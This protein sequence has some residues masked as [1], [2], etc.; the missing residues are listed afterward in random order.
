MVREAPIAFHLRCHIQPSIIQQPCPHIRRS[1]LLVGGWLFLLHISH[2][3]FR[4]STSNDLLTGLGIGGNREKWKLVYF[5]GL[6]PYPNFKCVR[7]CIGTL[8]DTLKW[9]PSPRIW[10]RCWWWWCLADAFALKLLLLKAT[11]P[12]LLPRLPRT[13]NKN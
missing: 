12:H 6:H 1:S 7:G 10:F 3:H 4:V 9:N 11:A 13:T 2:V 8:R 5:S